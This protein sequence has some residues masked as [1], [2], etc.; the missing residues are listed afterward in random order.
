MGGR[1]EGVGVKSEGKKG[2]GGG[3]VRR[4]VGGEFGVRVGA[5]KGVWVG[6]KWGGMGWDGMGWDGMF[7][8]AGCGCGFVVVLLWFWVGQALDFF[9]SFLWC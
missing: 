5:R 2:G 7:N 1:G 3:G 6:V 4:L 9:G 8:G